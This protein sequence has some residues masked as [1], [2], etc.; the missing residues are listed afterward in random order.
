MIETCFYFDIVDIEKVFEV[1]DVCPLPHPYAILFVGGPKVEDKF[2][3]LGSLSNS[4]SRKGRIRAP[5]W[6]SG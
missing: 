2:Y 5:G 3:C 1:E 4:P 6:L